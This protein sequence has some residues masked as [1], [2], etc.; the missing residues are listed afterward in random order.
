[1]DNPWIIHGRAVNRPWIIHGWSM[2]IACI[3]RFLAV[4]DLPCSFRGPI[5]SRTH[6]GSGFWQAS[7]AT[8]SAGQK[9]DTCQW[10]WKRSGLGF[11]GV[12]LFIFNDNSKK[13][14]PQKLSTNS[15]IGFVLGDWVVDLTKEENNEFSGC[16]AL[17]DG[18]FNFHLWHP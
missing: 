13:R 11:E 6:A 7:F 1:M 14:Y 16:S 17:A 12:R 4:L 18:M 2:N 10:T 9:I 8:R 5:I 3:V 15:L